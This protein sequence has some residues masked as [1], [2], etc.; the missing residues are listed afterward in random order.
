[1]VGLLG[2]PLTLRSCIYQEAL[3]KECVSCVIPN[4]ESFLILD[5]IIRNVIRNNITKEDGRRLIKIADRLK[6]QGAEGIILG[7]TELPLVFPSGYSL[8]VYN[9]VAIL[10]KSLLRNYYK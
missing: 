3:Q 5:R 6:K 1:M 4:K 9:S 2:T 10:A 7:C 8:P